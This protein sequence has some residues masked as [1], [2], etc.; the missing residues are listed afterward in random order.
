MNPR[1]PLLPALLVA[2][3]LAG[4]LS[5]RQWETVVVQAR[6]SRLLGRLHHIIERHGLSGQVPDRVW[7][8]LVSADRLVVEQHRSLS[9]EIRQILEALK[10]VQARIV[11]LKGGAYVLR[12]L[13]AGCGRTFSDI[14]IL[15]P[16]EKLGEVEARLML[17]GWVSQHRDAYDQ[18]YYRKWMHEIPPMSHI[19]RGTTLDIH[20]ALTPLT[21][22]IRA[23]SDAMLAAAEPLGNHDRLMVLSPQDMVLHSATHLFLESEFHSGLRDLV[24][25]HALITEFR[26]RVPDF[27]QSVLSRAREVGLERPL[28]LAFNYLIRI[29]SLGVSASIA[30][31][32][33]H[34]LKGSPYHALLDGLFVRALSPQHESAMDAFTPASL[35]LLY[36]RGHWLRMPMHLLVAHL[37]YKA[38]MKLSKKADNDGNDKT[39]R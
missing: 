26:H 33:E 32:L 28:V 14:D 36:I 8:H 4:S 30:S 10:T 22:R 23:D 24:D 18:R 20:H 38:V 21:S 25:L 34:V 5:L 39:V 17:N 9:H 7:D 29:L 2:P 13:D 19:R 35:F 1:T 31:E 3:A 27:D 11:V 15:V 6:K 12:G 16:R 37:G